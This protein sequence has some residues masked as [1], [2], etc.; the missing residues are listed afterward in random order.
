MAYPVFWKKRL[1]FI[2]IVILWGIL[3]EFLQ[4]IFIPG[5][6]G[7]F[8]DALANTLGGIFGMIFYY[9]YSKAKII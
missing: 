8:F 5:R 1:P 9:Y 3:I 4:Q 6:Y 2:I 7:D